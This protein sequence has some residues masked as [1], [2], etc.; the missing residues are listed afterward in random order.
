MDRRVGG[1]ITVSVD[2]SVD[3]WMDHP[4]GGWIGGS[5]NGWVDR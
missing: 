4:V 3:R 5:V 1:W 2:G